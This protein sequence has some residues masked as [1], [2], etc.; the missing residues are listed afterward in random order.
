MLR[1]RSLEEADRERLFEWRNRP[2]VARFMLTDHQI[3]RGEHERWFA[4]ALTDPDRRFWIMVSDGVDTG[5]LSIEWI[6]WEARSCSWAL[7]VAEPMDRG[8]GVGAAAEYRVLEYAFREL[9]VEKAYCTVLSLNAAMMRLQARFGLV[10]ESRERAAFVR[11]G[12]AVDIIRLVMSRDRWI[13]ARTRLASELAA[14]G[15]V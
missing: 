11:E 6:D 10:E 1:L 7:Y 12:E 13:E 8:K 3:P 9:G 4:S 14:L 15:L 2:E 5:L